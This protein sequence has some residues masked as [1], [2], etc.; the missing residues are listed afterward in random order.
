M[1]KGGKRF[2]TSKARRK[3]IKIHQQKRVT[4]E[5]SSHPENHSKQ[6]Y[7]WQQKFDRINSPI[8]HPSLY[9]S[10]SLQDN[11]TKE[12]KYVNEIF[13]E[14]TSLWTHL[15]EVWTQD[16]TYM[17]H[18]FL[19]RPGRFLSNFSLELFQNLRLP[20][21]ILFAFSFWHLCHS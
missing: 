17:H 1:K 10:L 2:Y 14:L 15:A 12:K 6:V 19:P 11:Q 4:L 13:Q 8:S 9:I 3:L 18:F 20:N 7:N 5:L 21:K 16:Q